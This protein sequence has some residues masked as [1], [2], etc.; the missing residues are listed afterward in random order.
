[1]G[2]TLADAVLQRGIDYKAVVEPRVKHLKATYPDA[3]T[4]SAFARVLEHD[5]APR[6]LDW[7]DGPKPLTLVVLVG[8]LLE[9][10][11][12]TEED[13]RVWLE[14]P[15]NITRLHQIKG[16]KDKT[17]D[18]L[19]ILVGVQTVAVDMHLFGFLEEA[20][21]HTRD[22]AEAHRILLEVA[23]ILGVEAS[24]L[25][26]SIWRYRSSMSS[27]RRTSLCQPPRAIPA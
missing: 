11:I 22:Y 9:N 17:T 26:H 20:G 27:K 5:G 3:I 16:I 10:G 19:R 2:A 7:A 23:E 14:L 18:Y 21:I 12:E 4:T 25:D 24:K 8:V 13:L 15:A 1:M 6:V